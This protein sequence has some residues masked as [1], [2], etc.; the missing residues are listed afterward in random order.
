MANAPTDIH[1]ALLSGLRRA[2]KDF[3]SLSEVRSRLPMDA[4][5]A[6]DLSRGSPTGEVADAVSSHLGPDLVLHR[7]GRSG[8]IGRPLDVILTNILEKKPGKSLKALI[9]MKLP[10]DKAAVVAVVNE[11]LRSGRFRCAFNVHYTPSLFP[12]DGL[13]PAVSD[14][15]PPPPEAAVE[16]GDEAADRQGFKAAYDAVG[17]GR[18]FVSI[19]KL[20]RHLGWPRDRFDALL[21]RLSRDLVIQLQGG[22][23]SA[24]DEAE[25]RDSFI[26]DRGRLRIAV[27]WRK[28]S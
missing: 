17:R 28:P 20:R 5:S 19:S 24:M 27:T 22:D 4:L 18:S 8:Y 26:D 9:A 2:G 13:S 11:G 12:A 14:T 1:D 21:S 25:I 7:K 23:P 10:A 6:L 3:L 16:P 15:G